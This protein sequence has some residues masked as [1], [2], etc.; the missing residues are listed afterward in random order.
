[1]CTKCLRHYGNR[2]LHGRLDRRLALQLLRY[3]RTG[4]VPAFASTSEQARMLRPLARFLELEGW[5]TASDSSGALRCDGPRSVTVALYPALL[6]SDFA[7]AS[8][9][10]IAESDARRVLLP[11]YLV[12]H[13]LPSA[14]Q[15][16][17]GLT[18][19]ANS[20]A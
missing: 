20:S 6:A 18:S 13:D 3:F 19:A 14:Y 9:P 15:R 11:D 5:T 16:A 4:E 1:S 8:H 7:E 10:T 17:T 2:F 12:E